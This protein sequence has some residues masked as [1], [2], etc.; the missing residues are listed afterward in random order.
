MMRSEKEIH[1]SDLVSLG[2]WALAHGH[3]TL[4]LAVT[5]A[6]EREGLTNGLTPSLTS[7]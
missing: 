5:V 1:K 4:V 7:P 2:A 3:W 6:I